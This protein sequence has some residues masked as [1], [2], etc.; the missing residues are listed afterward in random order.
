MAVVCGMTLHSLF[1]ELIAAST[2]QPSLH[3][4]E[5]YLASALFSYILCVQRSWK[6]LDLDFSFAQKDI[7]KDELQRLLPVTM[8]QHLL[9]WAHDNMAHMQGWPK[10]KTVAPINIL[11]LIL[12]NDIIAGEQMLA[13]KST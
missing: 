8:Y 4:L 11:V 9:L 7:H 5:F 6:T 13:S 3:L 12:H 2:I 1:V 10:N